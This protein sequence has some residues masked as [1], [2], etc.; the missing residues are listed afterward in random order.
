MNI[1]WRMKSQESAKWKLWIDYLKL[2]HLKGNYLINAKMYVC[3]MSLILSNLSEN[4][5]KNSLSF[6][7][8]EKEF[9]QPLTGAEP[10]TFEILIGRSSH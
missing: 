3:S 1:L 6:R 5:L 2:S 9:S 7:I 4:N 8:S 10:M